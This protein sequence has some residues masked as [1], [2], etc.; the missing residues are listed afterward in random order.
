MH[1]QS[2]PMWEGSGNNYAYL[3]MCPKTYDGVII[4]PANP[5]EV[6]PKLEKAIDGGFRLQA[7]INTHHHHDHAG[8]NAEMLKKYTVPIIGGK[9]CAHVTKTPKHEEEFS[10]GNIKVKALH[11]P[12]HTQDSICYFMEDDEE[13]VVFTGDTLFI[14]GCGRFFEGT[15][16]EMD[17]ALN[18]ILGSL[19]D[20]T[21][22][23][24]GHEYTKGNVKFGIKVIQ[25]D[26]IKDLESFSAKNKETQGEFTIEQEKQHNVFMMLEDAAVKK[27]TGKSE[28]VDVMGALREAKNSM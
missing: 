9:D 2:F 16:A 5:P 22:V 28:R 3:V 1:I 8:G 14:G 6:I 26:A 20:D 18:K 11:T 23:Y 21:Y 27:F 4:D 17:T 19:P 24:P 7:I 13:R 12:C 10:V 25:N 15:P